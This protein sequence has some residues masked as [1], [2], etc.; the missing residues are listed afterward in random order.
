MAIQ[1]EVFPDVAFDAVSGDGGSD[2]FGHGDAQTGPLSA[3][4]SEVGDK[5][6]VLYALSR[7]GQAEKFMALQQ[8]VRFGEGDQADSRFLPLARRRLI[9]R[10]PPLVDIRFRNP[11]V[12][13]RL[14]LL[15]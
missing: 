8:P 7:S 12:L 15:G 4:L 11:W 3:A 10:R 14:I 13:A 6:S 1:P 5:I 2:F 9:I